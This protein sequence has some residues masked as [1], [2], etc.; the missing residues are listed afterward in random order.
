MRSSVHRLSSPSLPANKVPF[1]L[2]ALG[3][4]PGAFHFM[5]TCCAVV[6]LLTASSSTRAQ[7]GM[8]AAKDAS[9]TM[10]GSTARLVSPPAP[11][12]PPSIPRDNG[13]ACRLVENYRFG[14]FASA[15]DVAMDAFGD[16][17]VTDGS[18]HTL[19]KFRI[20]GTEIRSTGGQGW[21]LEQFDQP[22]GIDARMGL[23]VYVADRG[24]NRIVRLDRDMHAL[25]TFSTRDT[26]D[27]TQSFGEPLDVAA[28]RQGTLYI[29][30]GENA[31]V[32]TSSGFAT[33][34]HRF[35][36]VDAG[37][38]RLVR[39]VAMVLDDADN[40]YVLE[41]S[42]V[43]VFDAFGAWRFTFGEGI[44]HGARGISLRGNRGWIVT[45]DAL[46][47]WSIDG[48]LEAARTVRDIFFASPVAEFRNVAESD[49]NVLLLTTTS[50]IL[51][52]CT[53]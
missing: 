41:E 47:A 13:G 12:L 36:G 9:P 6:M 11:I 25:G 24:N 17:Y 23:T 50:V 44:L 40:V 1:R 35:G 22:G 51:L 31:R 38:G 27:P 49:G 5:S 20:D 14:A 18:R 53:Q 19:H 45:R 4:L 46:H 15:H 30:D 16:V 39:P 52:S 37:A 2:C 21:A 34:E 29:L 42:R 32:V 7:T 26:P 33:I 8:H 48:R 10:P 3:I 28:A 43:V